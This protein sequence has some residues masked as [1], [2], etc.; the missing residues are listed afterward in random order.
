MNRKPPELPDQFF[1]RQDES[2]D[3]LFYV[4]PRFE[5][6]IDDSTID[7]LTAFY[8]EALKPDDRVLDLM[9][10]WI[11]HLP[12]EVRYQQVSGLGMN[13]AELARNERLDDYVVGT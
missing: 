12:P 2:G 7:N 11:S 10:S 13:E 1:K 8:R 6:H 4:H 3:E 9:S 5:T